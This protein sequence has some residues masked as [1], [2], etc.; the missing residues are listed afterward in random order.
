MK[1]MQIRAMMLSAAL[2]A[3]TLANESVKS[4]SVSVKSS[5]DDD[6]DSKIEG[7]L[8]ATDSTTP[9]IQYWMTPN[10]LSGILVFVFVAIIA[11]LGFGLLASIQ[12]PIY[13]LPAN[14]EKNKE[15]NREWQNIWGHI[16][17]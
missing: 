8:K 14:D 12:V 1:S 15:N 13:Q 5:G 11:F 9:K 2:V 7:S 16:E 4:S 17:K 10:I 6:S 3:L